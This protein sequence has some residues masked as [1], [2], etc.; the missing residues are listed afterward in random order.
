MANDFLLNDNDELIIEN[1]DF[2]VG[3]SDN[4]N[5]DLLIRTPKGANKFHPQA[6]VGINNYINSALDVQNKRQL[7]SE[8]REQLIRDGAKSI[9]VQFRDELIAQGKYE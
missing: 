8:I 7:Q 5:V 9:K 6:G 3:Y 2:K 1:G 4:Q